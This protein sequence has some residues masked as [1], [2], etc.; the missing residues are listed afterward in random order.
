MGLVFEAYD[1]ELDC[2]VALKTLR[3]LTPDSLARFKREFRSLQG[4]H[5]PNLV[6]LGEL[7]STGDEWFFTMELVEGDDFLG[8]VR[9]A[10]P[11]RRSI[12]QLS[13]KT[14]S[15]SREGSM[16]T[17]PTA[18]FGR[19]MER[20]GEAEHARYDEA[21]L[22]A[23]LRQLGEALAKLHEEGIVHR[24][25][26]PSNIRIDRAGRLVLLDFGLVAE[27]DAGTPS[28]DHRIVGTP[29]YMAP[30]QAKTEAIGPE[31]DL[32]SAGVV[33][34]EALT[35]RHPFEGN[36]I[37]VLV[38]KQ[39]QDAPRASESTAG[40]DPDLDE[41][42]ARLLH[43][44]PSKRPTAAR[45]TRALQ[46]PGDRSKTVPPP[47]VSRGAAPF[48]G[49]GEELALLEGAYEDVRSVQTVSVLVQGESGVGKSSLVR[50][51]IEG[52][53][54]D[55]N[56]CVLVGRCYEREAV[57][58][59]AF[60]GVIDSLTRFLMHLPGEEARALLPT[61]PGPLVQVFPVLRRVTA[62]AALT[63][64]PLPAM[65]PLE[66]RDRAFAGLRDLLSRLASRYAVVI[67]IDDAQWADS[68]SIA[69]L[70]EVLRPPEAPSLLLLATV[71]STSGPAPSTNHSLNRDMPTREL[72]T[73]IPGDVRL[74]RLERLPH[75]QACELAR[76]IF[77]GAGGDEPVS[78]AWIAEEADGHPLFIDALARYSLLHHPAA[79]GAGG[80]ARAAVR[81]DEA[82]GAPIQRLQPNERR[83]LELLAMST[84]PVAQ[85]VLA[86]AVELAP[87][88]FARGMAVL[89]A[90][91][92]VTTSGTRGSDT[93][94][95][96]HDR[97]RVAVKQKIPREKRPALHQRLAMALE[98][99]GSGDAQALAGHWYG[100]RDKR[101]AARYAKMAADHATHALAFD[102]AATLY[103]WALRLDEGT[104]DER[105]ELY[106]RL[107]NALAAAGRGAR[108]AHA[109]RKA[110]RRANAAR[111]L[112]LRRRAADQLLRAGHI[113]EGLEAM[114]GVLSAIGMRLPTSRLATLVAFLF[115]LTVVRI[116]G[117]SFRR[118]DTSEIAA[119]ELTRID[120]CWSVALGLS[121]TDTVR[122][123]VFHN[124][125]LVLSLRSGETYRV[126][127]AV[128][129]H[130]GFT[131]TSG[132]RRGWGRA[133]KMLERARQLADES[134]EP[135]AVGWAAGASCVAHYT[136]GRFKKALEYFQASERI[137]RECPGAAWE[138][139]TI[140]VFA[141]N[142]MAQ[143]GQLRDLCARAPKY[144]RETV[145][146]G[147]LYGAVNLRIG[148]ANFRWLV[149]DRP[150]E[151]RRE[152]DEAMDQWSKQGMHL[153]HF[154]E[155]LARTNLALYE[156]STR[157]GLALLATR[158]DRLDRALLFRV[159]SIRILAR[160]MRARLEVAEGLARGK[161]GA[162]LLAAAARDARAIAGERM[163]WSKPLADLIHAACARARGDAAATRRHLEEAVAGFEGCDMQLHRMVARA[164]LGVALGGEE[165]ARMLEEASAWLAG[166]GVVS[167][168]KMAATLGPGLG[169][170]SS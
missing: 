73:A 20:D 7:I 96:Y 34:Y 75:A 169:V 104:E 72:H 103:D 167:R 54:K 57:P 66:L 150:D 154:Y 78:A 55:P 3:Q 159:Q 115:W 120:T 45:L 126:A 31:A 114:R 85:D 39:R 10:D 132:G 49:R 26:K 42:C 90:E 157:E 11:R 155:L 142:A 6:R 125:A 19:G 83:I 71:R 147:D 164:A 65:D 86:T 143:L 21:R 163:E 109:F 170:W 28:S 122:G 124:R 138:L 43:R 153:E 16:E 22:R 89:R 33:L 40:I 51:F 112:D 44:D 38:A 101:Q 146:R 161:E 58:Y 64:T 62:V 13:P 61:K 92:L 80:E 12:M 68:D 81:L 121:I 141:I 133:Q 41:L 130:A 5:H 111:A 36:G 37:D 165:G 123:A 2:R 139:D 56:A 99:G 160:F 53:G 18:P 156:G 168:A 118:R 27:I 107:G 106:E 102:R 148:Y 29:A 140:K 8:F 91:H 136:T 100:A 35:G 162:P 110:A 25:V 24:D 76:S 32:Y 131:A 67:S 77:E 87:D 74:I 23:S 4:I 135:H 52:P 69:L 152:I 113:D 145:E 30:E 46:S 14:G 127:R 128:A 137:W 119:H 48:I 94:E 63:T 93:V 88:P 149:V 84:G 151:A 15:S 158:W 50:H 82:I 70:A 47:P 17:A 60:D 105:A 108:A 1:H 95:L 134:R 166:E 144:L 79:R 97:I 116:R 129:L 9:P 59:K 98:T 117:L